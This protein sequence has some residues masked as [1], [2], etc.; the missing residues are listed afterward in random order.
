ME[1]INNTHHNPAGHPFG[2]SD[3]TLVN[4]GTRKGGNHVKRTLST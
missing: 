4:A 3:T 2:V 1:A